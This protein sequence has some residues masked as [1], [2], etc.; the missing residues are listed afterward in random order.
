IG[1]PLSLEGEDLSRI[2]LADRHVSQCRAW[3][4]HYGEVADF[5]QLLEKAEAERAKLDVNDEENTKPLS[6][7]TS[8]HTEAIERRVNLLRS[9]L[10]NSKFPP[11]RANIEAAIAGYESG[12]GAIPY[13]GQYTLI[14]AGR[15][16]DQCP[17]YK[18]FSRDRSVRLDR[19][20]A[21][22]GEGWLWYEPPLTEDGGP[23]GPS[24]TAKKAIC[25]NGQSLISTDMDS[26]GYYTATLGF[27]RRKDL[28]MREAP[29][30]R[31]NS[32]AATVNS[33]TIVPDP[34]TPTTSNAKPRA[35]R[36][37]PA[38][39]DSDPD[40][41][42]PR[43]YWNTL[44]DSGATQPCLYS[45]DLVKLRIDPDKYAAQSARII[46]TA[47]T[48]EELKVFE[49]DVG[50][51]GGDF[52]TMVTSEP[53]IWPA[54]PDILGGTL[55]V[56]I[57]PG[58]AGDEPGAQPK[59]GTLREAPKRL[60]GILPFHVCYVSSAPGNRKLWLG[61]DRRDVLGSGRMPGQRR[62]HWFSE[63]DYGDESNDRSRWRP[64]Q[65][66]V[67]EQPKWLERSLRKARSPRRVVF[68]HDI[69]DG[70]ER[71]LREEDDG[72]RSII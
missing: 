38:M 64:K 50:V 36:K 43:V 59:K 13:S 42:G 10:R 40:K 3:V 2:Q 51:F 62:V 15:I 12:S 66:L 44:L 32:V 69:D 35:R 41:D 39:P 31:S 45:P 23:Q 4:K 18:T 22:Y 54:E 48:E 61:E 24:P 52:S 60:S 53:R 7:L 27:R 46:A 37:R 17:D 30:T 57:L 67:P 29:H 16:V 49:L 34:A 21:E 26:M 8:T 14:W 5:P 68:E 47:T 9:V 6:T 63:A 55:P 20:L 70:S 58:T 1:A 11:E 33:A 19:Y 65:D 71:V 28:V 25:L 72:V 56:I